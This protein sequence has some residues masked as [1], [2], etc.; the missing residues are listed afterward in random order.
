MTVDKLT[1]KVHGPYQ[2]F[3]QA[4]T[5]SNKVLLLQTANYYSTIYIF[6]SASIKVGTNN[7]PKCLV[8]INIKLLVTITIK[9]L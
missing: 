6:I 8:T 4:C 7:L 3:S 1:V 2:V 5:L 9:L